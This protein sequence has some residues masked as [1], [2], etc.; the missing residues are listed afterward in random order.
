MRCSAS[1]NEVANTSAQCGQRWGGFT[2][3]P[4]PKTVDHM[5][6]DDLPKVSG[7]RLQSR[8]PFLASSQRQN[9]G[10][11]LARPFQGLRPVIDA[12]WSRQSL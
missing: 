12:M 11:V 4:Q 1:N 7:N 2:E 9:F 10:S 6:L 3:L 5:G 8:D